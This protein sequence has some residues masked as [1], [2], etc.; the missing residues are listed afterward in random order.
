MSTLIASSTSQ[1]LGSAADAV[2]A[3][4]GRALLVRV[5][6]GARL[7]GRAKGEG[8]PTGMSATAAVASRPKYT[9]TAYESG[10]PRALPERSRDGEFLKMPDIERMSV[11][12]A[13]LERSRSSTAVG[14]KARDGHLAADQGDQAARGRGENVSLTHSV[15]PPTRIAIEHAANARRHAH[16]AT[17]SASEPAA[18]ARYAP[19]KAML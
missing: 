5:R 15:P 11:P 2:T 16:R 19:G 18:K 9:A 3:E 12:A 14:G 17:D 7:Q 10:V 8:A 1:R 6:S 4:P 13:L